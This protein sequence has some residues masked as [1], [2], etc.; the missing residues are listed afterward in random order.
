MTCYR[1]YAFHIWVSRFILINRDWNLVW[2]SWLR[3]DLIVISLTQWFLLLL[4]F[5][6]ELWLVAG[7]HQ[8]LNNLVYLSL[9]Y[10]L[11]SCLIFELMMC[12][13]RH[14][15]LFCRNSCAIKLWHLLLKSEKICNISASVF[16]GLS[17]WWT[18]IS[19]IE[20]KQNTCIFSFSRISRPMGHL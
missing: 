2:F 8:I 18:L 6:V 9:N 16:L 17:V 15:N 14:Q 11:C 7:G 3:V 10:G 5:M 13:I 1:I 20:S 4:F 12:N 19:V